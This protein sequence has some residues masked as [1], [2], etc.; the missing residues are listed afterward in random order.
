MSTSKI[1]VFRYQPELSGT[2]I[3]WSMTFALF[4][5][6]MIGLLEQQGRISIFS[7]V[8]FLLF[9]VFA[10]VGFRRKMILTNEQLKVS[11]IL[12]KNSYQI[13]L[14]NIQRVSVGSHGI[15]IQTNQKEF[16]YV[17]FPKSKN[18]FVY[19]LRQEVSF[20]GVIYGIEK[21]VDD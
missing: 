19:H 18:S 9:L 20:T 6:S 1:H 13:D 2:V 8:I 17:M 12:K 7:V 5:T 21:S 3:Y 16:A 15:T 11:A 10:F 4:F 14:E